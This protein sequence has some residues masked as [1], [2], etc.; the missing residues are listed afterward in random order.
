MV[1]EGTAITA[2]KDENG[3]ERQV[4]VEIEG[5]FSLLQT[6]VNA[7]ETVHSLTSE[8]LDVIFCS[9]PAEGTLTEPDA[10]ARGEFYFQNQYLVAD[11]M[12][13]YNREE[14]SIPVEFYRRVSV[15]DAR[16]VSIGG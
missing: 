8:P 5:K 9:G 15:L 14:S 7:F 6:G 3:Q 16:A 13:D 1:C 11:A 4:G 12:L 10:L 2:P